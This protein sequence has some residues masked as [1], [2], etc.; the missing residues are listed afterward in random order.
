M[1]LSALMGVIAAALLAAL[2]LGWFVQRLIDRRRAGRF[3][4][5]D[6]Y[7]VVALAEPE[8]RGDVY[9]PA[10]AALLA[11]DLIAIDDEGMVT[12]TGRGRAPEQPLEAALLAWVATAEEP[13]AL[14]AARWD[15][16][17]RKRRKEFLRE[18]ARRVRP[19][20]D[21]LRGAAQSIVFLLATF[22]SVQIIY[23]G[24]LEV[25]NVGDFL[26]S[27]VVFLVFW[28]LILVP[29]VWIVSKIWPKRRDLLQKHCAALPPHP[30]LAA[31]NSEQTELLR[32]S[33]FYISP[34]AK[35]RWAAL[36][37]EAES[38]NTGSDTF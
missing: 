38:V 24:R 34:A 6:P 13:I 17:L 33:R 21:G 25:N 23:F 22:Y 29:A 10:A 27:I 18:Q 28:L 20:E 12:A 14:A 16:G 31:L 3:P 30:A 32:T 15:D 26:L 19:M 5:L 9:A 8:A 7:Y 37:R 35:E 2:L 36:L 11:A 4:E 1:T